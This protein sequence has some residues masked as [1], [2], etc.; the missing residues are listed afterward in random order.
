MNE[1]EKQ[2]HVPTGWWSNPNLSRADL[3]MSIAQFEYEIRK[4]KQ[5]R[6]LRDWFAGRALAGIIASPNQRNTDMRL[7]VRDAFAAADIMLAARDAKKEG[8]K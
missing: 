2:A 4:L 6:T 8:E 7:W 1:Q 3:E 5:Q